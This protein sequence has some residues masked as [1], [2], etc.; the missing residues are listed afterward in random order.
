[1]VRRHGKAVWLN[2]YILEHLFS[3]VKEKTRFNVS[4]NM[5][6]FQKIVSKAEI[7]RRIVVYNVYIN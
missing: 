3:L 6:V 1:M 5:I 7:D 4:G 2:G